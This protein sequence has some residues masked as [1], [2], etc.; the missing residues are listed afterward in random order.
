MLALDTPTPFAGRRQEFQVRLSCAEPLETIARRSARVRTIDRGAMSHTILIHLLRVSLCFAAVGGLARP[1]AMAQQAA[2]IVAHPLTTTDLAAFFDPLLAGQLARRKIAG[3]VVVVV[4][5][6]GILFA[7]GYGAADAQTGRPMTADATLVRPGSISKLFTGIA[8]MQLVEQ[9]KLDLD[10]DVNDY[11]DFHI[12]TPEG[13]VPVTLRRLMTHRAGFEEHVKDLFAA[14]RETE[15]L[16]PW[17]ARSLPRRL[18]PGGDVPGYSN[19][20]MGLAGYIV[21]RVTGK[22]YEDYVAEHILQ[23]L[24]MMHSTFRQP[25]PGALAPMMAASYARSDQSPWPFFE[26]ITPSPAGALSATGL[27]M[28]R[29]MLALLQGGALEGARLLSEDS[30]ARM[31]APQIATQVGGMGLVFYDTT[32]A[33]RRFIGHEGGTM[34]F[35]SYLLLSPESRLGLFV[36]YNGGVAG[37]AAQA[38]GDLI[39]AFARRYVPGPSP[40]YASFKARAEDVHVFTGVYQNSRRAD[41][42]FLRLGMLTSEI[43]VRPGRGG[44]LMVYG[45]PFGTGQSFRQVGERRFRGPNN[46]EIAFEEA[47]GQPVRMELG[48]PLLQWQ[49]VPLHLDFRLLAPAVIASVLVAVLTLIAWPI[50]AILRRL[51]ARRWSEDTRARRYHLAVRLVLLLQ[52]AVVAATSVLYILASSNPTILNSALDPALAALYAC[53]WLSVV[54]SF[55]SFWVAGHYWRMRIGGWWARLHHT[56]IAAS[57]AILAWFCLIARIAGTTMNY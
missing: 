4:K 38:Q 20:G 16:G 21:E 46:R 36:S 56:F 3:V 7:R 19:Y 53:G 54:G 22:P 1:S 47:A 51:R 55:G 40:E 39:R 35:H 13:G 57:S 44:T 23:P 17:L 52:C 25:L 50:A 24:G 42:T 48:A 12:P 29:F 32:L 37:G 43:W 28:G 10:R 9:G 5:D 8:V 31:M 33:G 18:F 41:S 49:R 30:V 34:S 2:Q 11:L 27:D 26:T 45:G 6:E 14:A 15:R